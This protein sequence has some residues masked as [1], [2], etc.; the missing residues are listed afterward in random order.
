MTELLADP[1][2]LPQ[3]LRPLA[4]RVQHFRPEPRGRVPRWLSQ[5][6]AGHKAVREAAVLILIGGDGAAAERPADASVLLTRRA[7]TLRQHS[8]QVA[9][10]GGALEPA[11]ASLVH[12]AL[13]EANEETGV[14]LD[15]VLPFGALNPVFVPPSGFDVTP[16]LAYWQRPSPVRPM[17]PGETD[18]VRPVGVDELVEPANRLTARRGRWFKGPAFDL[19][20]LFVWGFTGSVLSSVLSEAGW[21]RQWDRS[22]VVEALDVVK[23]PTGSRG[24][25]GAAR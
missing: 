25:P 14:D 24:R 4:L 10:P 3:W 17:H 12:A 22:R 8:G 9:F 2:E 5:R 19:P 15:G 16:V 11:D 6:L 1:A 7:T 13:R 23:G 18:L 21:A 20:D